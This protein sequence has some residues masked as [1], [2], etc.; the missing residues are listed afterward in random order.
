MFVTI[1]KVALTMCFRIASHLP[2]LQHLV[3]GQTQHQ[4]LNALGNEVG[5]P[6]WRAVASHLW[7]LRLLPL[8]GVQL[9]D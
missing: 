3:S 7:T 5:H 9:Y 1:V 4:V 8:L 2:A 6:D